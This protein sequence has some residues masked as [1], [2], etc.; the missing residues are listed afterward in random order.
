MAE[1]TNLR[2]MLV[3]GLRDIYHAEKQ[4]TKALPKMIKAATSEQLKAGFENHL[5][6]TH[7]QIER[8]EQCFE[9]LEERVRGKTCEAMRGIIE[10]A[11]ETMKEDM[12]P[13][14]LDAALVASAQKV[15]HYEIACYGTVMTWAENLG[16]DKV[17]RLLSATLDEEKAT[18]VKLTQ[19]ATRDINPRAAK[20]GMAA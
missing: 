11:S 5:E 10:E 15:E 4:I 2:D 1:M 9:L 18:D 19:L 12:E 7:G 20:A 14:V 17:A 16:L 3:E 6:E 8:L 13:E